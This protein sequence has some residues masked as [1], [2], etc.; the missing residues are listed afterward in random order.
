MRLQPFGALQDMIDQ[1]DGR[2]FLATERPAEVGSGNP[3]YVVRHACSFVSTILRLIQSVTCRSVSAADCRKSSPE[4]RSASS[5]VETIGALIAGSNSQA[6]LIFNAAREGL[7]PAGLA[8]LHP[9]WRTPWVSFLAFLDCIF[10]EG[11]E[12]SLSGSP[13][14]S[15]SANAEEACCRHNPFREVLPRRAIRPTIKGF[16]ETTI[17]STFLTGLRRLDF[18]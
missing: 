16:D 18:L 3:E 2:E 14:G 12:G 7:L 1:L 13:P 6:R 4:Y 9:R 17:S 5:P 15:G 10:F 11:F 8:R